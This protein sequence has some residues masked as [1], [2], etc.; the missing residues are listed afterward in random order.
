MAGGW[1]PEEE[2]ES[3]RQTMDPTLFR[4]EYFASFESLLGAVYPDFGDANISPQAD[5]GG[6]LVVGLDFNI[7]PFCAVV[8]RVRNDRIDVL[9]EIELHQADTRM[10]S[11]EILRR[12]PH[13]DITITPDPTGARK[14]TSSLCLS[15]H[16]ILR[17]AGFKVKAP[18]AP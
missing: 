14:Q 18:T 16:A 5:D 9:D 1:I 17:Q 6:P 4:Q 10:M 3:Q 13:R 2:V 8:A 12:Y 15:D 7:T 11:E